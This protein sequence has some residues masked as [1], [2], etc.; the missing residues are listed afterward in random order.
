MNKLNELEQLAKAAS[1]TIAEEC[2]DWKMVK[3]WLTA[4]DIYELQPYFNAVAP[5]T[6]IELIAL[7]RQMREALRDAKPHLYF[8]SIES[9]SVKEAI[10]AFDRWEGGE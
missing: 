2:I 1:T 4:T 5:S 7:V 9:N 8:L 3:N 10:T 6:I